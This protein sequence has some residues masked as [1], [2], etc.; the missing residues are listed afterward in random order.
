[1]SCVLFGTKPELFSNEFEQNSVDYYQKNI[2]C[3]SNATT[4]FG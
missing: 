2:L 3:T 4:V 1:M